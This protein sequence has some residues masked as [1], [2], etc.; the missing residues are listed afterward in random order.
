MHITDFPN[1]GLISTQTHSLCFIIYLY[2]TVL[3]S[4]FS[5]DDNGAAILQCSRGV[6]KLIDYAIVKTGGKQYRVCTGDVIR[7][8]SVAGDPGDTID[9]SNV[10]MV[11]KDGN[12][13]IGT[14]NIT[15]AK[16]TTEILD[17]GR[18]KKVIVFK[19]KAKTTYR[20]K[21][22]HRQSYTDLKITGISVP[23]KNSPQRREKADGS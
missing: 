16:V 1:F 20:K 4:K 12:V 10:S 2:H 6:F 8:E 3:A 15:G 14:P 18:G 21:N 17:K 19:Y 11:S 13:L 23:A 7:V 5:L 22:G 9:L